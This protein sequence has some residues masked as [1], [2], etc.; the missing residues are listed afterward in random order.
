MAAVIVKKSAFSIS[1]SRTIV[2]RHTR[3]VSCPM[4]T[5]STRLIRKGNVKRLVQVRIINCLL[6]SLCAGMARKLSLPFK[7][8]DVF[9]PVRK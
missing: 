7:A 2:A 6:W 1:A 5:N 3:R 8:I 9:T 4:E